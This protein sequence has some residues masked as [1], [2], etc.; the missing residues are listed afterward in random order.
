MSRIA[1]NSKGVFK[2]AKNL[3][4]QDQNTIQESIRE[5][6][7][8]SSRA[9]IHKYLKQCKRTCCK[10]GFHLQRSL[11]IPIYMDKLAAGSILAEKEALRWNGLDC[12]TK[13]GRI[14]KVKHEG[15]THKQARN[16]ERAL[17]FNE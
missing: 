16:R 15:E 6:L 12:R 10:K 2:A 3:V 13:A 8:R 4:E 17:L 9:T 5:Y 11:T 7:G 14:E 1:V